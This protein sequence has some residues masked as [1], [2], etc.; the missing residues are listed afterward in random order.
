LEILPGLALDPSTL[1]F[2]IGALA[3]M[4][5]TISWSM[6]LANQRQS[7]GLGAWATGTAS[8]GI[9]FVLFFLRGHV[10]WFL[11]FLVANSLVLLGS[12][13]CLL[14]H[15]RLHGFRPPR[16]LGL[17]SNLFGMSGV[18]LVYYL[19][20]PRHIAVF[21]LSLALAVQLGIA[22]THTLRH[23]HRPR[24]TAVWLA[25][26]MLLTL[27]SAYGMRALVSLTAQADSVALQAHAMP[28]IGALLTGAVGLVGA[29]IAFFAMVHERQQRET[30]EQTRRDGITGLYT[31]TAF[32]QLAQQLIAQENGRP[33]AVIM[34]DLDHFKQVNDRFGHANGDMAL[35][36]AGR[37]MAGVM[38]PADLAARY[39]GEEF[40]ML[41]PQTDAGGAAQ[42][43]EALRR[44]LASRP[45]LL[46]QGQQLQ[47]TLS[48]GHAVWQ[49]GE[50]LDRVIERADQALYRAKAAGRNQ[51]CAAEPPQHGPQPQYAPPTA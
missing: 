32:L 16:R 17:A 18:L 49:Q 41:L 22:A 38:R 33:Y 28:Q 7:L 5:S 8:V 10:S 4:L 40:C 50:T 24:G 21:T 51:V 19:N 6:A 26:A 44:K 30:L 25:C 12:S 15:A 9:A 2:S 39:G 29:T 43:A 48:A 36:Q 34:L 46:R 45:L 47:L 20:L 42:M 31:R 11:S 3:L 27:A 1:I 37:I 35:S 23:A 14:A 13:C